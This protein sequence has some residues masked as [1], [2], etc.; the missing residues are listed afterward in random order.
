MSS[1]QGSVWIW[2]YVGF[3]HLSRLYPWQIIA[4][5]R[6]Q[7]KNHIKGLKGLFAKNEWGYSCNIKIGTDLMLIVNIRYQPYILS[8]F[9]NTSFRLVS[10][11]K[12]EW[13]LSNLRIPKKTTFFLKYEC[14]KTKITERHFTRHTMQKNFLESWRKALIIYHGE[15]SL[16]QKATSTNYCKIEI[17]FMKFCVTLAVNP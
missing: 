1:L 13:K 4:T 6:F 5:Q 9:A 16:F 2:Y 8:T 10:K 11:G 3:S 17:L 12:E 15:V 7:V 14:S